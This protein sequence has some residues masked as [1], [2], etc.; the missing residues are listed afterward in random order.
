VLLPAKIAQRVYRQFNIIVIIAI[1]PEDST[2]NKKGDIVDSGCGTTLLDYEESR[3]PRAVRYTY[4]P[5]HLNLP[6][7]NLLL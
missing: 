6:Q 1:T 7:S 5:E 2:P 3:G 4:K